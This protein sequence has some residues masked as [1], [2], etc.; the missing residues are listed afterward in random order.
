MIGHLLIAF[1][2][3]ALLTGGVLVM[4][5]YACER[6]HRSWCASESSMPFY[7]KNGH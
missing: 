3:A 7:A 4:M 5:N 1:T 2:A 6:S